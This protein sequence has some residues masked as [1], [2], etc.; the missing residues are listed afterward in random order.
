MTQKKYSLP[1]PCSILDKNID[2]DS[3]MEL[4]PS[5]TEWSG[6]ENQLGLEPNNCYKQYFSSLT[7]SYLMPFI[8][9]IRHEFTCKNTQ[10]T[11]HMSNMCLLHGKHT[12]ALHFPHV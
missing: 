12:F 8:L 11:K 10:V 4:D 1:I 6:P 3:G 2:N 5:G 9:L 7:R